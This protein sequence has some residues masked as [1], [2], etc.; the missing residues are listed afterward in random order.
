MRIESWTSDMSS[1]L[2]SMAKKLNSQGITVWLRFAWEMNGDWYEYG[3]DPT[4][5][6]T[7]FQSVTDAVRAATND[8][9]MLWAPNV[10]YG[11]VNDNAGYTPYYPGAQCEPPHA[12]RF[13]LLMS[14]ICVL[15]LKFVLLFFCSRVG[16]Q[17]WTSP[18]CLCI[19]RVPITRCRIATPSIRPSPPS[20]SL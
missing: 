2:A 18:V 6:V 11:D 5:Y 1:S 15:R 13:S 8:T 3:N 7:A 10:R 17:T 20:T 4:G 12:H 9:Y 16:L 19:L 14:R